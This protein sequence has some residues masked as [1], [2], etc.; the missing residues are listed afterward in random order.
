VPRLASYAARL[1]VAAVAFV[2]LPAPGLA[3]A[4][5][6]TGSITG[7]VTAAATSEPIAGVRVCAVSENFEEEVEEFCAHSGANGAYTIGELPAARYRVEFIP[8]ADGLNYAYQA[9]EDKP[10]PFEANLVKVTTVEVPGIDAE[11]IAGGSIAGLVSSYTGSSPIAGVEVCAEPESLEAVSGCAVSDGSGRYTIVGL[12]AAE[13]RVEFIPPE[14]LEFIGQAFDREVGLLQADPVA[15]QTGE[16][17]Q[18]VDATLVEGGRISGQ[19]SDAIGHQPIAG[20]SACAFTT[21]GLERFGH[22]GESGA[23]GRYLIRRVPPGVYTVH[24]FTGESRPSGYG[25]REYTGI[26]GD[27]PVAVTVGEGILAEG[28]DVDLFPTGSIGQGPPSCTIPSEP[29]KNTHPKPKKCAKGF[30]AKVVRGKRRCVK[31]RVH[32]RQKPTRGNSA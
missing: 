12:T 13:Y 6:P 8:P 3:G 9:W 29:V 20:V 15:V 2:A 32:H 26:C 21:L 5:A 18:N 24:Y 7:T 11:L 10:Q 14:R 16:I 31:V 27:N 30:T 25:P 17:T 19:V 28:I 22:C 4:A 23:D 1:V